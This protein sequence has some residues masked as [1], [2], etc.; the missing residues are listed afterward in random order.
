VSGN[1]LGYYDNTGLNQMDR[2]KRNPA[3][4]DLGKPFEQCWSRCMGELNP[5]WSTTVGGAAGIGSEILRTRS[6]TPIAPAIL[7]YCAAILGGWGLGTTAGCS[8]SC[9]AD[10]TNY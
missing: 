1:P 2:S 6:R 8:I 4:P 9:D 3:R 7:G 5:A 10:S